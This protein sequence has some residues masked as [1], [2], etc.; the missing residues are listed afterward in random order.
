MLAR[1]CFAASRC[2]PPKDV[3]RQITVAVVVTVKEAAFLMAVQRIVGG[4]EIEGDLLA[5]VP[6]P[7]P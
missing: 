4:V 6:V 2:G 7:W 3:Q 5:R 1:R